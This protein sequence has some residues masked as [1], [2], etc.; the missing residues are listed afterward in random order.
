MLPTQLALT[1]DQLVVYSDFDLP[2][3]HRLIEDLAALRGDIAQK[4]DIP[5]SDEPIH[6]F[7]F[8]KHS[9]YSSYIAK[10]YPDLADRRAFFVESDTRLTVYAH[11]G[12]RVAE[13]LRHEVAHG[14]LHAVIP[15]L[16]LWLDEGLAE[17]FETP[18]GWNGRNESHI[19]LL[20]RLERSSKW[21]P[22]LPRLERLAAWHEMRQEDY[23][24]AWLWVHF[25]I[26][27]SRERRALLQSYLAALRAAGPSA[28]LSQ[29]LASAEPEAASSVRDH[30]QR[31]LAAK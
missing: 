17:Y 13:D 28:P 26:E 15:H 8:D 29:S 4:L 19:E 24:E 3:R 21:Q 10:H 27:T 30:L 5:V 20:A 25:L 9:K 11:W 22:D 1:R 31:L 18:R 2:K 6:I 23:A 7:L 16:P 14:Y 12:E